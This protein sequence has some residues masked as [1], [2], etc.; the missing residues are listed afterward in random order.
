[1]AASANDSQGLKIAVAAFVSLTV[2]LA[3]TS[4]F[5][6]S[7]YSRTFE[8]LT[9]ANEKASASQK[10]ASDALLQYDELRKRIGSRAEEFDAVKA[11]I[12]AEEKKVTDDVNTLV[13]QAN[14]A[15]TKLQAAGASG[16]ELDDARNKVQQ[17]ASA[18]L[19]EPNK[20]YMSSL[21]RL[22]DLLKTL[23]MLTSRSPGTIQP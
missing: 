2:I 11:E 14:E 18:Y 23:V 9:A 22:K 10:A 12:V 8:Q 19:T 1:M 4:Y 7:N 13:G 6:Y 20:N 21:S 15:I 5:L 16:P 17:I 3:V